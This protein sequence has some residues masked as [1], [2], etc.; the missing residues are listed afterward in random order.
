VNA[1]TYQSATTPPEGRQP[2]SAR[3]FETRNVGV[4]LEI[5]PM[6]GP[7]CRS[8][9]MQVVP[10]VA[11]FAGMLQATGVAAKYPPQPVFTTRKVT[12]SVSS[13]PGAPVLLG[14]LSKPCD[15]GVNDRKDDGRTS[16]AYIRVTPVHP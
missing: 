4:T 16:L 7:Q 11:R 13:S 12:T 6:F 5:E 2:A 8:V 9:D 10:Q 15:T 1:P 3:A 14:T